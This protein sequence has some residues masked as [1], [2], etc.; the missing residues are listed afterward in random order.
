VQKAVDKIQR[1]TKMCERIN[2]HYNDAVARLLEA[3]KEYEELT[4]ETYEVKPA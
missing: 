3:E 4:G 2:K 1:R